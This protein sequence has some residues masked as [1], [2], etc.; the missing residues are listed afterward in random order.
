ML[1]AEHTELRNRELVI[2]IPGSNQF[3]LWL[4]FI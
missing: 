3:T 1:P 4:L 2:P